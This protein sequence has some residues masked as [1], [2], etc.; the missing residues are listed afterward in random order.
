VSTPSCPT[1]GQPV[2]YRL[3][4][5]SGPAWDGLLRSWLAQHGTTPVPAA[6]LMALWREH[7]GASPGPLASVYLGHMLAQLAG[8]GLGPPGYVVKQHSKPKG[9]RKPSRWKLVPKASS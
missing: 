2:R 1:C 4:P 8:A 6:S 5:P 9:V 7:G 3:A